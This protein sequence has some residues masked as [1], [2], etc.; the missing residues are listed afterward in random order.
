MLERQALDHLL[1]GWQRRSQEVTNCEAQLRFYLADVFAHEPLC[2][3]PLALV[4]NA[5]D[6][7]EETMQRIACELNQS[8]TTFLL[9]PT[10]LQADWRLRSFTPMGSDSLFWLIP[11]FGE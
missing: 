1:H 10:K 7:S 5:Q 9:P 3:N 2:G 6:L 4:V 8:E 11:T